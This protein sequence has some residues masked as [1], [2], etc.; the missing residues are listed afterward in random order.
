MEE[1]LLEKKTYYNRIEWKSIDI[2]TYLQHTPKR[3]EKKEKKKFG[4]R[5]KERG[6]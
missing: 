1:R 2:K 5:E 6:R 4:R 3:S